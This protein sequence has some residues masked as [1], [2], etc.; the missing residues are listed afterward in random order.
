[1]DESAGS[2]GVELAILLSDAKVAGSDGV[3]ALR[4]CASQTRILPEPR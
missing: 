1:M 3:V 4:S 2:F